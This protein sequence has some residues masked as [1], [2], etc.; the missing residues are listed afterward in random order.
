MLAAPN[1]RNLEVHDQLNP[2]R[3]ELCV[4]VMIEPPNDSVQHQV[5]DWER[6]RRTIGAGA[7]PSLES[8]IAVA[9]DKLLRTQAHRPVIHGRRASDRDA[10]LT[11]E[12][13]A[14]GTT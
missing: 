14:P 6:I 13:K 4:N 12:I 9:I 2:A 10:P 5:E 1:I 7:S 8:F 11:F 3:N